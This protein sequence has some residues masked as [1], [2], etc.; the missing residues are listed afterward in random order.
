LNL[1]RRVGTSAIDRKSWSERA[2]IAHT[3]EV[4]TALSFSRQTWSRG[5]QSG[6]NLSYDVTSTYSPAI[7]LIGALS[8][9]G[10]RFGTGVDGAL[11]RF[12]V[13]PSFQY[14]ATLPAGLRLQT[15]ASIGK[16]HLSRSI[17]SD[18]LIDVLEEPHDVD[19]TRSF[20]LIELRV[21]RESI[22]I[23]NEARTLIL[24]EGV[25]YR[26]VETG[27]ATEIQI[28]P[29]SRVDEGE[30]VLVTYRYRTLAG[31]ETD[32]LYV[33]YESTLRAGGLSLRH[34]RRQRSENTSGAGGALP[35]P[36]DVDMWYGASYS[37]RTRLGGISIDA[38]RRSRSAEEIRYSTNE[39]RL[40]YTPPAFGR[41]EGRLRATTSRT[42]AED[43]ITSTS[44]AGGSV[45]WPVSRTLRVTAGIDAWIWGRDGQDDE[46]FLSGHA[47]ATWRFGQVNTIFTFDQVRRSNGIGRTEN[48]WSVRVV[49]RF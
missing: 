14:L 37:G 24:V 41:V 22:E 21:E 29:G 13:A 40:D 36:K 20:S 25:D 27:P 5:T 49:R 12:R 48:R 38:A 11:S 18:V 45:A 17:P 46:R 30:V 16:E 35:S 42:V 28:L 43:Q 34:G 31:E 33:N 9:S 8:V 6:R 10:Q 26:I 4:S 1:Y 7:A 2:V 44:T 19:V 47:M 15:S 39:A 32:L 3:R 23:W